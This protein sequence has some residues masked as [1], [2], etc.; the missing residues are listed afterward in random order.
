MFFEVYPYSR[1]TKIH[2]FL[3]KYSQSAR[4]SIIVQ[5]IGQND[6]EH[7]SVDAGTK[8][9]NSAALDRTRHRAFIFGVVHLIFDGV[10]HASSKVMIVDFVG[11]IGRWLV[12]LRSYSWTS[13]SK[14]LQ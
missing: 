10:A 2:L 14:F 13:V 8:L 4:I 7:L 12:T 1:Y 9:G 11:P 5:T 6:L 3:D